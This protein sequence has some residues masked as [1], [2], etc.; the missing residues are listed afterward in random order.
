MSDF[1]PD[2]DHLVVPDLDLLV[3]RYAP[4]LGGRRA[5]SWTCLEGLSAA[6]G[7]FAGSAR[8]R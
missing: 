2:V 5:E 1:L 7:S 8:M 4:D 3:E 6:L